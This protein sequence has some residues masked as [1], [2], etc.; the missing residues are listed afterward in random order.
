MR[1]WVALAQE[2]LIDARKERI[3]FIDAQQFIQPLREAL[4][5][6]VEPTLELPHIMEQFLLNGL[7]AKFPNHR[8]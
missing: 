2:K 5:L 6:I 3:I 7:T 4:F 8:A 1:H